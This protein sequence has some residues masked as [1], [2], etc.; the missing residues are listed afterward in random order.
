[1]GYERIMRS[2]VLSTYQFAQIVFRRKAHHAETRI[3]AQE[4]QHR[5]MPI[6]APSLEVFRERSALASCCQMKWA[7]RPGSLLR[8]VLVMPPVTEHRQ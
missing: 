1:M 4:F 7:N 2:T 3:A 8:A 5:R 6:F